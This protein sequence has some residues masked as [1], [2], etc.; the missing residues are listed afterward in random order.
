MKVQYHSFG[1]LTLCD[2]ISITRSNVERELE[3]EIANEGVPSRGDQVPPL[4]KDV[5][6]DQPAVNPP[7]FTDENIRANLFQ[8]AQAI[9][10]QAQAITTEDQSMMTQSN[11]KVVHRA[12]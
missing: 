3:E 6:D 8:I 10:T 9:T 12:H 1:V 11:H 2:F 7:H 5:I 4:E